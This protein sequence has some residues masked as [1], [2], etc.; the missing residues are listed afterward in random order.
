M[1]DC[2]Y[3]VT[4]GIINLK[5]FGV[6]KSPGM[7]IRTVFMIKAA[8]AAAAKLQYLSKMIYWTK[9]QY[10][11]LDAHHGNYSSYG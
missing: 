4:C 9:M 11:Q 8:A 2:F 7:R 5:R 10:I 6:N 3:Y 1:G